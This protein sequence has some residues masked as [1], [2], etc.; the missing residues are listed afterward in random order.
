[1][2]ISKSDLHILLVTS[3]KL[4]GNARR[5]ERMAAFDSVTAIRS[6]GTKYDNAEIKGMCLVSSACIDQC[7]WQDLNDIAIDLVF[8]YLKLT[9][10]AQLD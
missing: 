7:R 1:M 9:S 8:I 3:I 2:K 5:T 6:I 10:A 4:S